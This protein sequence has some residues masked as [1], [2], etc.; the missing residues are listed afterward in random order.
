MK[1][2]VNF[3]IFSRHAS[4]MELLLY[5]SLESPE[6]VE[7]IFLDPE[8]NRDFF[9]WNIFVEGVRPGMCYT[10]RA[11]GP[12][13]T[14]VSGSRFNRERE[15]LDPWARLVFDRFWDR[16][17]AKREVKA[18]AIRAV[19]P[20]SLDDYDWEGVEMPRHK[21]HESVIYEMHVKGFNRH[22]YSGV[23]YPGTFSGICVKIPY[24]QELGITHIE[25]LPI[26]AF[27]EQDVPEGVRR[28]GLRNYWGYSTHSFFAPHP[29]YF[30]NPYDFRCLDEF[31]D[32]V[33]A[34]HR[35]GIGIILDVVFNHTA[36]G[37]EDGPIINFKGLSNREFYHLDPEDKR[38][39]RNFTGCGNTIN[40]NHPQVVFFIIECLEYWVKNFHID[41]F[42]FDLAS[43]M[44]RG[45]DGE[46]M[47]HAP[48]IWSLEFSRTL[49]K[50]S[51]IAEAWD[52]GGL[53]QVGGFPGYRWQEWNGRYRDVVRSFVR[54]DKGLVGEM[55]TRLT[56]SS[57]L[58]HPSGRHPFNSVNFVTCHDGFTLN[59]L[60]SY[61]QK[62]NEANGE[63][64]RDGIDEN[65][66]ANYGVEGETDDPRINSLRLRQAKNF[67]AILCLSLGVPMILSGDEVLRT[68][69]GNNNCWCQDNELSWL[70]WTLV[71]KNMQMLRFTR[72][73]IA[74]RRRHPCLMR[75]YFLTGE[76][77]EG[78]EFA[79][80]VWHGTE[81]Y[82]PLWHDPSA[83]FLAYTMSGLSDNEEDLHII[84]NMEE[85]LKVEVDLP[86]VKKGNWFLAVD[87]FRVEPLDILRPSE[88]QAVDRFKYVVQPRSVVVFERRVV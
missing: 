1:D 85:D 49:A 37:W 59:D 18:K 66:S 82:R 67:M 81:L 8:E 56:G 47:W 11:D 3:C 28:R 7:T 40:C 22:P 50:A 38:K 14:K 68:Q 16:E 80:I 63:E 13:N 32:M 51:L 72:E 70:D 86:R 9:F 42:R 78:R 61:S 55:A 48:V 12:D 19:V 87:T 17:H 69:K 5:E 46:P 52:A 73:M 54:G 29:N 43:V 57:D 26:M 21:P 41:G 64:N 15:L 39:Y 24:L 35:A 4:A 27:D 25:L 76:K 83:R 45:E 62:H 79:D 60:V 44:A 88:Q 10:W 2:G 75:R 31:R 53:Y 84:L 33:K 74:F 65:L 30:V 36:E 20:P 58:Y 77:M 34:L 6:P 23:K 71:E